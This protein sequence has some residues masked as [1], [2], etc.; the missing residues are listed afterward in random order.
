MNRRE[1]LFRGQSVIGREWIYGFY[2]KDDEDVLIAQWNDKDGKFD[3]YAVIPST[4]GQF[5]GLTDS[6]GNKVFEGDIESSGGVVKLGIYEMF[7]DRSGF[8]TWIAE[9]KNGA[10]FVLV[11]DNEF[12]IRETIVGTIHDTHLTQQS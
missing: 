12:K 2:V 7:S 1:I 11:C 3:Y 10:S 4:I 9:R 8:P 5:T 6:K